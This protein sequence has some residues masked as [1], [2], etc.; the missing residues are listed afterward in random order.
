MVF[1]YA[2]ELIITTL[3]V[4]VVM[5]Q[6]LFP[7]GMGSPLFPILRWRKVAKAKASIQEE[8]EL[9]EAEAELHEFSRQLEERKRQLKKEREDDRSVS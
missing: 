5:T 8:L 7:M 9:T 3:F 1:L 2:L 6:V 4:W